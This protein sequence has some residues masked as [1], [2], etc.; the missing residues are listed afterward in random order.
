MERPDLWEFQLSLTESYSNV[1]CRSW[2]R[3]VKQNSVRTPTGSARTVPL[4]TAI[5]QC[6][7]L[8]QVQHLYHVVDLDIKGFFDNINHTKLIRQIWALGIRDKKLLCII[9]E[10]LKA[11]VVLPNGDKIYP[12]KELHKAVSCHH[13][14]QTLY[15]NELDWWIASQ[16]EQMPTKQILKQEAISREQRLKAMLTGLYAEAN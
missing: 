8:I 13:C 16:W 4:N 15:L 10:M 7:R 9:K 5:A 6:M 1:S 3:Y 11:P 12:T 2:S 14:L